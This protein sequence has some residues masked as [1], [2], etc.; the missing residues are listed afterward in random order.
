MCAVPVE[1]RHGDFSKALK[2]Y[3]ILDSCSQGTFVLEKLLKRFDNN[4]KNTQS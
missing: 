1:L 4:H 3:A 2:I